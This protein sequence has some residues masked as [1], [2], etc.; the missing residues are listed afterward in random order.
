[1]VVKSR[2]AVDVDIIVHSFP[3]CSISIDL[4]RSQD[5]LVSVFRKGE[6]AHG[7]SLLRERN[8]V[9]VREAQN[10]A[11]IRDQCAR[12]TLRLSFVVLC[13]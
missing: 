3:S 11:Q 9:H 1:M 2:E 10:R 7:L 12:K 6:C 13:K 4:S 5:H 8:E